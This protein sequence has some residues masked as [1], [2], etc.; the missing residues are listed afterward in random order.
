M[1]KTPAPSP[2]QE[3][4][5]S[6]LSHAEHFR[7]HIEEA[8][9]SVGSRVLVLTTA[10]ALLQMLTLA[11]EFAQPWP[12]RLARMS[13][14]ATV[15]ALCLACGLLKR[16]WGMRAAMAAFC[17]SACVT[18]L[19][20]AYYHGI[21]L[22]SSG[23]PGLLL[24]SLLAAFLAGRRVMWTVTLA[25][26]G[27][28]VLLGAAQEA[29]WISG[30]TAANTPPLGSYIVVYLTV[31]LLCAWLVV[32]FSAI[33]WQATSSLQASHELLVE[34]MR[35][36][37][38]SGEELRR[39]EQRLRGL[40]DGALFGIQIVDA[41]TAALHYA[42]DQALAIFGCDRPEELDA[43]LMGIERASERAAFLERVRKAAREGV[44]Q[45]AW[46]A[47]RKNGTPLWLD[48][49]LDRLD[50][51]GEIQ[52]V[53]FIHDVSARASAEAELR[54]HR[55]RLQEE[56]IARTAEQ[57]AERQKMQEIIEALPITLSVRSPA[58]RYMMVNRYFEQAVGRSRD[59][60]LGRPLKDLFDPAFASSVL[61]R[62]ERVLA[63][64]QAVTVEEQVLHPL[65]GPR[66]YLTTT[67]P[68]TDQ[69]GRPYAVLNLGTDVTVL[70]TLQ[71]ELS[72]ARDEAQASAKAKGDFLANMSHEIRTPLNAMLGLAQLGRRSDAQPAVI[73]HTFER[74]LRAGR[75]LQ[76]V[77]DDVLD[78]TRIESGKQPVELLP[79]RLATLIK[80]AMDLVS[81]RAQEK[82]LAL[83]WSSEDLP[84]GVL[85]D[86][87][88]VSQV[89]VNLLSNAIKF[90]EQ[91]EVSVH[92]G[93]RG[94]QLAIAIRD[95]GPGIPLEHQE[96]IFHA[97]EQADSS[98]TRKYGGSGL[99]LAISRRQVQGMGGT[100]TVQSEPG[101]GATFVLT[102]PLQEVD[103]PAGSA[104][105]A[106]QAHDL[107]GLRIL[108]VDD[109]DIN[110]EILSDM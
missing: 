75:H 30:P 38:A 9:Q 50:F 57:R 36:Q 61:R 100:L 55:E 31:L 69:R 73:H 24:V 82:G 87:L 15:L 32:R 84:A 68:L 60:V 78:Y 93:R 52:V 97:F 59:E 108:V 34:A 1:D 76:G 102:L 85:L 90:T 107:A 62:D 109:V 67:V 106:G 103:L 37:Q 89:L 54:Q 80:D 77:I 12:Q 8:L 28:V 71:R 86:P 23:M 42:N 10:A 21:G 19:A 83:T 110:R 6:D 49:K 88:R 98:T 104:G 48:L 33:F 26:A 63:E 5:S 65:L 39:S 72:T 20:A 43:S 47:R 94:D 13:T 3:L 14:S 29:G 99:G 25:S 27:G 81:E 56:V 101:Q 41:E 22:H 66:D 74:I 46:Q 16:R 45:F 17:L 105:D 35:S 64:G 91:G 51:N 79:V 4:V 40:L 95:T 18:L 70:K 92:L 53:I 96:R 11:I 2:P 44:Q 58:G 7:R